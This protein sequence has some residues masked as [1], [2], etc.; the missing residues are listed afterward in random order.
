M[1]TRLTFALLVA[2]AAACQKQ[3]NDE[4]IAAVELGRHYFHAASLSESEFN[5]FS[6]ATCHADEP[7]DTTIHPGHSLVGAALRPSYWGGYETRLIDAVSFC[8]VFFMRGEVL[9]PADPK[10]R[11]LY[12]YL[13]SLTPEQ[14]ADALPLTVVANIVEVPLGDARRGAEVWEEACSICHGAPHTGRG[15]ISE[16]ASIVPE[17][18]IEFAE[19]IGADPNLVLTEKVRHGQFFGVGGNMPLFSLEALSNEDLGA[20]LAYLAE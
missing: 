4:P 8:K 11:A 19:Q 12:E 10:G 9:D 18:S 3:E 16:L 1:T 14:A 15:R 7:D 20:L 2:A 5:E 6:C 17:E 13:V